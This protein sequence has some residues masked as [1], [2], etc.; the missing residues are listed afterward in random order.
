[1]SVHFWARRAAA[2]PVGR[3]VAAGVSGTGTSAASGCR[4]AG[5]RPFSAT[6]A[7]RRA[8]SGAREDGPRTASAWMNPGASVIIAAVAGALGW[9]FSKFGSEYFP[10]ALLLDGKPAASRYASMREMQ[11]VGRLPMIVCDRR[12]GDC[13]LKPH[14][15]GPG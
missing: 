13:M 7:R 8:G 15:S 2:S 1:M 10:R 4:H 5:R 14:Y 3:S 12:W 9:G 11:R 6:K